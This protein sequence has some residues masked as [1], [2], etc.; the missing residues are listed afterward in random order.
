MPQPLAAGLAP[1]LQLEAG[2]RIVV[3][4]L[5]PT[6]GAFIAGVTLTD[7]SYFVRD[8]SGGDE[9]DQSPT[10]LLVPSGESDGG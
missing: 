5:D 7:A 9:G 8:L 4:A 10:P 2:Y 1:D 3:T 6:T